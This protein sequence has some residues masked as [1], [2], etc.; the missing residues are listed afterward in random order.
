MTEV[1][2]CLRIH[3][4]ENLYICSN[5]SFLESIK[6]ND[7]SQFIFNRLCMDLNNTKNKSKSFKKD[8]L[9]LEQYFCT[10]IA[11]ILASPSRL[12]VEIK[13]TFL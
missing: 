2:Q 3:D 13:G 12:K 7:L 8:I 9:L 10:D 1:L 4:F 11:V 6:N 5:L